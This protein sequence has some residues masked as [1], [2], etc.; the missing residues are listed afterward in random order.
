MELRRFDHPVSFFAHAAPFLERREAENNVLLGMR[1]K[2]EANPRLFGDEDPY[3]AVAESDGKVAAA[4]FQTPP[5]SFGLA[6]TEKAEVVDLLAE[7]VR[8]RDLPGVFGPVELAERFA[9]RWRELTGEGARVAL[10]ERVYEAREAFPPAGVP[11][12][13]RAYR[14]ADGETVAAW[15][16]A[17]GAEALAKAP[18][19]RQETGADWVARRSAD[20]TGGI[21]IWEHGG[22]P[23]SVA[24]FSSPTRNGIRVGPVYTPPELRG[25]GYASAAVGELTARLLAGGR[26]LCFLFTDLGNPTSNAIYQ[27]VGYRPV[28]D[29]T[30]WRFERS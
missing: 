6:P 23:V 9:A 30:D 11:G 7:D 3:L 20:P 13:F 15:M 28:A 2:L 14:P 8:G 12:R 16:D 1:A 10:A 21:A 29:V 5:H 25:R 26:S 4:A 17:F 18:P 24:G 19:A 22:A 27:R